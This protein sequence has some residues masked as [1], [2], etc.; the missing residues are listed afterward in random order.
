M[1]QHIFLMIAV[2]NALGASMSALRKPTDKITSSRSRILAELQRADK[3]ECDLSRTLA[4][5]CFLGAQSAMRP[6]Q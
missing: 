2:S 4:E 6:S 1:R 5:F 3:Y